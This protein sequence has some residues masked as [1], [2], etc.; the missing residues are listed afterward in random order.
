MKYTF[1]P[2]ILV[3]ILFSFCR[4]A[5]KKTIA[6]QEKSTNEKIISQKEMRHIMIDVLLAESTVMNKQAQYGDA[7]YYT[8]KYYNYI[9]SRNNITHAQFE[10]SL[11]YYSL[12]SDEM[13]KIMSGVVDSLSL[14][15]SKI[16]NQ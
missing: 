13:V 5:N 7:H 16:N 2:L 15:Q 11:D 3:L 1:L 6:E 14:L 9:F 10:Q 4:K 12:H 8:I